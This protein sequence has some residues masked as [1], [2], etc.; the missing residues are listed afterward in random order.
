MD[1][2]YYNYLLTIAREQ[3]ISKAA[4]SLYLS[5]PTL[6]KFLINLES[7]IGTNLFERIDNKLTPTLAG[8][9][10]LETAKK[11][12]S[13]ENNLKYQIKSIAK[14]DTGILSLSITPT[15]GFYMLPIAIPKFKKLY[16]E[17][18]IRIQEK[19]I[20]TIEDSIIDRQSKLGF[21]ITDIV[22]KKLD[23]TRLNEEELVICLNKNSKYIN[24]AKNKKGFKYP[25]LDIRFLK[26]ET[27]YISDPNTTKIGRLSKQLF[28]DYEINP[29]IVILK[30]METR[31]RLASVGIGVSLS[32]EMSPKFFK[33]YIDKPTFLSVGKNKKTSNFIVSYLKNSRL[34]KPYLDFIEI[35]KNILKD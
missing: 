28:S 12:L 18:N 5:Q 25:W 24:L 32:Y 35:S 33:H 1:T 3:S 7:K 2:K 11:I 23:Y 34:E 31:L 16:P 14:Y 9:K 26:D 21:Y 13:L 22:D 29:K 6:S 30:N 17:F 20:Y 4:N 27:F 15:R 19:D 8:E 10:Y